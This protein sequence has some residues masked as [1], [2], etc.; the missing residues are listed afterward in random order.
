MTDHKEFRSGWWA[1]FL[2][3]VGA[4]G[5]NWLISSHPEASDLRNFGVIAQVIVCAGIS[6]W[7]MRRQYASAPQPTGAR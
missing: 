4:Q 3:A 2:M 7:L 5:C 1:G 6:L